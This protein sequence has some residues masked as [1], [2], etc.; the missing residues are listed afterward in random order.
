MTKDKCQNNA[1][2][3]DRHVL[4]TRDFT[5]LTQVMRR[6]ASDEC[7]HQLYT[8]VFRLAAIEKKLDKRMPNIIIPAIMK[9][10]TDQNPTAYYFGCIRQVC[11]CSLAFLCT[12]CLTYNLPHAGFRVGI[13]KE[14]ACKAPL[15]SNAEQTFN[16]RII[17]IN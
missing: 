15:H 17:T 4:A 11:L 6:G 13:D 1:A 5:P 12:P 9:K 2:F 10:A 8:V 14:F 3:R 7:T 16:N